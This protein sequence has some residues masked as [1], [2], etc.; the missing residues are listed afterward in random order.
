M[1]RMKKRPNTRTMIDEH[2][3]VKR[4]SIKGAGKGLFAKKAIRP[5][6]TIGHYTGKVLTDRQT[7]RKPYSESVYIMW[8]C[9]DHNI[10]GE[11]PL[12]NYTRY[13]NHKSKPN[14]QIV[15]SNRWKTARIEA[16]KHIKPGQEIFIDYGPDYWAEEE[17]S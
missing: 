4:S 12:A 11:G 8:V 14:G 9:K 10:L 6:D 2:F 16:I 5:G 7:E 1:L 15:T 13:I 3:E 17:P